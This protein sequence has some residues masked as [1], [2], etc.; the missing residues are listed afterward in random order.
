MLNTYVKYIKKGHPNGNS[1]DENYNICH[2]KY[3]DEIKG[4]IDSTEE[5]M[6]ELEDEQQRVKI[7]YRN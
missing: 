4:K 5:R 3:R 1:R 6:S 7:K 2:K